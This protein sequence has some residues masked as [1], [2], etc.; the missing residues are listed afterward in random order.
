MKCVDILP[1][2]NITMQILNDNECEKEAS[3][4]YNI[5]FVNTSNCRK[6]L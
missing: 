4:K 3:L 5:Q 1:A 6:K 2:H